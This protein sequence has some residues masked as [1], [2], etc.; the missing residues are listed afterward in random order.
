MKKLKLVLLILSFYNCSVSAQLELKTGPLHLF[1]TSPFVPNLYME[2]RVNQRIG[3]EIGGGLI[4]Y[5][6]ETED[7]WSEETEVTR[8]KGARGLLAAKFYFY[9]E[10]EE[11]DLYIGLYGQPKRAEHISTDITKSSV[12]GLGLMGGV[13]MIG[14]Q[15]VFVEFSGGIHNNTLVR[16]Q[17]RDP[18]TSVGL[19]ARILVGYQ[20][21]FKKK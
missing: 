10:D 13:K 16:I 4:D 18:E 21:K 19:M 2:Y 15:G 20:F 12:F 7:W 9:P 3:L 8:K 14:K 5:S 1:F 11:I 6:I 17:N